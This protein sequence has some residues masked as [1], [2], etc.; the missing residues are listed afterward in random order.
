PG[1]VDVVEAVVRVVAGGGVILGRRGRRW[2][3]GAGVVGT[4]KHLPVLD[5]R[6]QQR[7]PVPIDLLTCLTVQTNERRFVD[8]GDN[9]VVV[10]NIH[11]QCDPG[12]PTVAHTGD[13]A[14]FAARL[15]KNRKEDSGEN[16][17]D[18]D[19]YQQFDQGERTV[20]HIGRLPFSR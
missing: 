16:R 15:C 18:G 9:L 20:A 14:G 6:H 12:L 2:G 10:L 11:H 5:V 4:D 1:R 8:G 19:Y 3:P 17:D 13:G 7:R